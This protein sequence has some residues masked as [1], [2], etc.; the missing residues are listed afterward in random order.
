MNYTKQVYCWGCNEL[1]WYRPELPQCFNCGDVILESDEA[2]RF[3]TNI[4][5]T[6]LVEH[7]GEDIEYIKEQLGWL[8][9][10]LTRENLENIEIKIKGDENDNRS[11]RK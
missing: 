4:E 9:D 8:L 6:A 2:V 10:E 1:A 3:T 11:H 5:I 7:W